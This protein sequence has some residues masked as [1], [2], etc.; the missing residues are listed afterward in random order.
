MSVKR[1]A[2]SRNLDLMWRRP[3]KP[4]AIDWL[5]TG[6]CVPVGTGN[7]LVVGATLFTQGGSHIF[8]AR[9]RQKIKK[10]TTMRSGNY[11]RC[12]ARPANKRYAVSR[13]RCSMPT[14][15]SDIRGRRALGCRSTHVMKKRR[16][17]KNYRP[18]VTTKASAPFQKML[19][20]RSKAFSGDLFARTSPTPSREYYPLGRSE[21]RR[22]SGVPGRR[23][24]ASPVGSAQ[25]KSHKRKLL[26]DAP[27]GLAAYGYQRSE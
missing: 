9:G 2:A 17:V 27:D 3:G 21:S 15:A 18:R 26:P 6:N 1:G 5:A 23:S 25:Q 16:R 12:Q 19:G 22:R 11:D 14:R 4:C 7:G 8:Y 24:Q 20:S 10:N 13:L